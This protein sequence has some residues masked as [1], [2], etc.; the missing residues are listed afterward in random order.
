MSK[1][2]LKPL[3]YLTAFAK[4]FSPETIIFDLITNLL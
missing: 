3:V 2:Y 1:I 4:G